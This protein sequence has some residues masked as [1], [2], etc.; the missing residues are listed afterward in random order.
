[1]T[2]K[3][4]KFL[5]D[6]NIFDEPEED[7]E[8]IIE[9]DLPPPPPT[10]SEEELEAAKEAARKEGAEQ[11]RIEAMQCIEKQT[12]SYVSQFAQQLQQIIAREEARA[13]QYEVESCRLAEAIFETLFPELKAEGGLKDVQALI[14]KTIQNSVVPGTIKIEVVEAY[15]KPLE[16]YLQNVLPN[17]PYKLTEAKDLS[18]GDVRFGW[19]SGGAKRSL[20]EIAEQIRSEFAQT[21]ADRPGLGDNGKNAA[22]DPALS[23]QNA[24]DEDQVAHK[25][26]ETSDDAEEITPEPQ[27]KGETDE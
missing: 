9:E 17:H 4:E 5:F 7:E 23:D 24:Q 27:K 16:S 11:A 12:E 14:E 26:D 21:L 15:I 20:S 25:S 13:R 10:F 1:M 19:E 2:S 22:P 3:P 8:E 6:L 18:E